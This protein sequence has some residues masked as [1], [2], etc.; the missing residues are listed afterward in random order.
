[1]LRLLE[2]ALRRPD[3]F[4][5]FGGI[6]QKEIEDWL[7]KTR[8]TLPSDL[9]E[10]WQITG[11]GDVFESETILRPTVPSIPQSNFVDDDIE[12]VNL[13]LET[14]GKPDGLY[15]FQNGGFLS[16]VQL[17]NQN[18][19]TLTTNY[20]VEHEFHSLDEWYIHVLRTEF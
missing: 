16:A 3:L 5:W 20:A 11:G 6:P 10:L 15:I 8:L 19:V 4:A 2:D 7:L 14:K 17:K 12:S 13:Y 9:I 18:F 1:M